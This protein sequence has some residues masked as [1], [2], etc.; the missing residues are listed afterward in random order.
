MAS[1][2]DPSDP[3]ARR[4]FVERET[5]LLAV[6]FVPEIRLR[7]ADEATA[8]WHRTEAELASDGLPP[9][10]WAFPWAG[11]QALA[12]YILDH[13]EVVRGR[14]VVDFASGSGLVGIA[15]AFAG[16]AIVE[17]IDIDPF[18]GAA[19]AL[20]AAANG[21]AI[22]I[23]IEDRVGQP[24]EADLLL[25]GD[26]FYDRAMA[27]RISP[28]FGD[29]AEQGV[30][31]LAGDPGRAYRAASGFLEIASYAVDV[32]PALEGRAWKSVSIL[33]GIASNKLA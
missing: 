13:P 12:R 2:P 29:L 17:A 7:Q 30:E 15:A 20:N 21:V 4:R 33:R 28:W 6:P 1:I 32:H 5:R 27:A 11:G 8:L 18:A 16:A 31:I 22:E 23:R 19:I 26:V 3:E 9:P 24:I 25:A 10:F 14:S